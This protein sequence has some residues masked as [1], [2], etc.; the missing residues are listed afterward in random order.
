MIFIPKE[1]QYLDERPANKANSSLQ[2]IPQKPKRKISGSYGK[3][4]SPKSSIS[5]F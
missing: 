5:A 1:F 2:R 4:T 3:K